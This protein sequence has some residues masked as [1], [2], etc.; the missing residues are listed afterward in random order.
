MKPIRPGDPL[1]QTYRLSTRRTFML[2]NRR[3]RSIVRQAVRPLIEGL[4][5]RMLLSVSLSHGGALH[6]N[7]GGHV[8]D[9]SVSMDAQ[10]S[11]ML[12]VSVNGK[13]TSIAAASVNKIVVNAGGTNSMVS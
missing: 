12:D 11:S 5:G 7:G 1:I 13:T 10:N 9:I 6:V 2:K 8:D 3:N 4:E